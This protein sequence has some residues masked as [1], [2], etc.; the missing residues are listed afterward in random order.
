MAR[1]V[2]ISICFLLPTRS[3]L[4]GHEK[5]YASRS[6]GLGSIQEKKDN[7]HVARVFFFMLEFISGR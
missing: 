2:K 6:K 4:I 5:I 1:M 7:Y 3:G